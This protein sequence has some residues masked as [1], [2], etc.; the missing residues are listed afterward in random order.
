MITASEGSSGGA[1][2]QFLGLSSPTPAV[3]GPTGGG[4][5]TLTGVTAMLVEDVADVGGNGGDGVSRGDR[6]SG[7]AG[8]GD[9]V[10]YAGRADGCIAVCIFGRS[11]G[12]RDVSSV[13]S[14]SILDVIEPPAQWK[15]SAGGVRL[16]RL[17]PKN[18][19]I[20][21]SF[22]TAAPTAPDINGGCVSHD[23]LV[24]YDNGAWARYNREGG[25]L[26]TLAPGSC[27]WRLSAAAIGP[28]PEFAD[29][30]R[31]EPR[32]RGMRWAPRQPTCG[33]VS[34]SPNGAELY[35]ASPVIGEHCIY[36][37]DLGD[38]R[39]TEILEPTPEPETGGNDGCLSETEEGTTATTTEADHPDTLPPAQPHPPRRRHTGS[40]E[41]LKLNTWG[42]VQ[43][44]EFHT[45]KVM[46]LDHLPDG[47]LV[48]GGNDKRIVV[49]RPDKNR[50]RRRPGGC[51]DPD[52]AEN[53]ERGDSAL[54]PACH[55]V[56]PGAVRALVVTSDGSKLF[57]AGADRNIRAWDISHPAKVILLRAFAGGHDGFVTSVALLP[58]P[59]EPRFV[60]SGSEGRPGGT[61]VKGDGGVN[62]W[63]VSDGR[64]VQSVTRQTGDITALHVRREGESEWDES[65]GGDGA[66]QVALLSASKDGT[67]VVWEVGWQG[68]EDRGRSRNIRWSAGFLLQDK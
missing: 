62:V 61:W 26:R 8:Q 52:E 2:P 38:D 40:W 11:D 30:F 6:V 23:L 10:V 16:L 35:L 54:T 55:T 31:L 51:D 64:C 21:S 13:S 33:A 7:R 46:C 45:D 29:I 57:T 49:W 1:S 63:R 4:D 27:G 48:S 24:V 32:R 66:A 39:T 19:M 56:S 25:V 20:S 37:W 15:S 58:S 3:G 34:V 44:L 36:L 14:S 50:Q 28:H 42:D 5:G 41:T 53:S 18:K 9:C 68:P 17:F 47:G 22:I 59:D 65:L 60:V 43:R 67:V 12:S